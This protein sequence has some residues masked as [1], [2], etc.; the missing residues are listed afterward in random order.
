MFYSEYHWLIEIK[1][2][3]DHQL[4]ACLL[5]C[6][7]F[8]IF[9]K[10]PRPRKKSAYRT[11]KIPS[12]VLFSDLYILILIFVCSESHSIMDN[13]ENFVLDHATICSEWYRLWSSFGFTEHQWSSRAV[14][15]EEYTRVNFL[16]NYT[17]KNFILFLRNYLKINY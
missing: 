5:F 12:Y 10:M 2:A 3:N 9:N 1:T 14:K 15:V 17:L 8:N 13:K 6:F 11:T 7:I 4:P 16:N